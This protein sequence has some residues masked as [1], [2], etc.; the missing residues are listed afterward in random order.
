M[1]AG[2]PKCTNSLLRYFLFIAD[3]GFGNKSRTDSERVEI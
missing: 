1:Q 2:Q 3:L